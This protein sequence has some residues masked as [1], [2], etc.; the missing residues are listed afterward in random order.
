MICGGVAF[1][2]V[3]YEYC[4]FPPVILISAN[5]WLQKKHL[6][7]QIETQIEVRN[8]EICTT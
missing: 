7:T 5:P 3:E 8:D 2:L 1:K 4:L 6:K